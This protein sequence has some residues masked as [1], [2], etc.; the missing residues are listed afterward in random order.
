MQAGRS[1]RLAVALAAV[2]AAGCARHAA[3]PPEASP[4]PAPLIA[5]SPLPAPS[6]APPLAAVA[7]TGAADTLAQVR[8]R[9]SADL[10][11]LERLE[12][13]D[14]SAVLA[15]FSLEPALPG[16]WRFLTPRMIGFEADRAW[17]AAARIR[18][19]IGKGLRDVRG[20]T[21]AADVAWTFQTPRISLAGLPGKD[22]TAPRELRPTLSVGSNVALDPASL[23]AHARVR[24]HG[25]SGPG[26]A[27]AIPPD[28][29]RPSASPG[30]SPSPS[31]S[32][33][34]NEA[35]DPSQ[36]D[37]RYALVPA[38]ALERGKRYDVTIEPG[39]LPRAGNLA[40]D[41]AFGGTFVTHDALRFVAVRRSAPGTRF[42]D[43]D[44]RLAF[45]TP[46]DPA[47]LSALALDPAPPRGATA[48]AVV[49]ETVGINASL[50]A[51]NTDYTVT[52]GP[53]LRDT[54]GQKLGRAQRAA[55]RTGDLAA[56]VW[57]PSG[58]SLFAAGRDVR[59]N[60]VAV[61]APLDVRATFRALQPADV[62]RYPDP[63]GEP[64]RGDVLPA[65]AAWPRLDAGGPRNVE[66]TIEVPLRAKLG[67]PAGALAYGVAAR[68]GAERDFTAAGV[69]QLTDLGVF[70]QWFPAGGRVSVNRIA[71]GAP[72]AGAQVEVYPSQ[73]DAEKKTTPAACARATTGADGGARFAGPAF[74][75]CAAGDGGEDQAP[76]FV[77]VV[78]K[79]ADWTYVR[80][81]E[82]TGAYAGDFYNG[83]SAGAPQQR[84]TIFSDRQLYQPGETARMT[85]A[86]WFLVDGALRRG[87]APSYTL[88]LEAPGGKKTEL[89]R[90]SL[91]AYG[92][93]TFSVPLAKGAPLGYYTV[94]ASAGN[95]EQILGDFRVAEFK[96]P[97]FKVDLALEREVA[98]RGGTVAGSATNAYLF[99]APLSGATTK[100]TVTRG[101]ADFSPKGRDDFRFGR[102]W[103]WPQ[104]PPDAATDVLE[105]TATVDA[106][107]KSAVSVPVASD[108]PYPMTYRVDAET[109]DASNVSVADGKT[110]T[111]L[112]GD[113]LIGLRTNDVGLAGTALDVE[114][115]ATDASGAA[116]PG[117]AL[118]LELQRAKYSS[119]TQI[120]EG[121]EQAVES[122]AYETVASADASSAAGPVHVA[123]TPPQPGTYRLR[124]NAA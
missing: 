89:G 16:R 61:N 101:P 67:A 73:A 71:D 69:V 108:L 23:A 13:P 99:G 43:G 120:V 94:R 4:P 15:H 59:L 100:F 2:F 33:P 97:N 123:L 30:I 74:A 115:I 63:A 28:T 48:F 6:L 24:V 78:R 124:A 88:A 45:T 116:R 118:H 37:W 86:G 117:T 106:Q 95:G 14:E 12:S 35:F 87:S 104:E 77:T 84:G 111:A 47:S 92:L 72:V 32:P 109:T 76:A 81:A 90:A 85:A 46:L 41:T 60:V 20:R 52:I 5:V 11:P 51:P 112:P 21:L 25:T 110:F 66:R 3:G 102:R 107:G 105:T 55:F 80:T 54:F 38:T 50:L 91:D 1:W 103:F 75:A 122:V 114:A 17:P 56:D 27:L 26:V 98:Q 64:E 79:D 31:P 19:R 119:A 36:H 121:A 9:F 62:V 65:P 83:W 44:P 10:I 49:D 96:P 22:D 29:A 58:T 82:S 7:P 113:T 39:V 93:A 18:V 70:A 68:L 53:E 57:A 40:S 8:V 34:P 42:A